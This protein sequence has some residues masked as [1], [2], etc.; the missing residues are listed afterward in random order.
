M[1]CQTILYM[2]S[3]LLIELE[4]PIFSNMANLKVKFELFNYSEIQ[5]EHFSDWIIEFDIL[6]YLHLE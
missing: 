6:L 1:N 3:Y 5:I 4:H 2:L